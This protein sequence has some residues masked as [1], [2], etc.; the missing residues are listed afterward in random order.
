M[1]K[2]SHRF[3]DKVL[4]VYSD[5]NIFNNGAEPSQAGVKTTFIQN[6]VTFILKENQ[7]KAT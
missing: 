6:R 7:T 5:F 3:F 1:V 4:P 2:L